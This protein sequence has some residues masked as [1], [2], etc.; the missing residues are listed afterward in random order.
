MMNEIEIRASFV[1]VS[2]RTVF[3]AHMEK[4]VRARSLKKEEINRLEPK[5]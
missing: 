4:D 2:P 5:H 1:A 3:I